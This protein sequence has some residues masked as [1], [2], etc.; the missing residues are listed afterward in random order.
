MNDIRSRLSG[1]AGSLTNGAT[2][3]AAW[4]ARGA[5]FVTKLKATQAIWFPPKAEEAPAKAASTARKTT[6][7]AAKRTTKKATSARKRTN[8]T[9]RKTARS[10]ART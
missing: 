2:D 5:S 4:K 8:G 1:A 9:A 6:K 7:K 10:A 3:R